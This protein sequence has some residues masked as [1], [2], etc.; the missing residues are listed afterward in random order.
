MDKKVIVIGV[1]Q[2]NFA[3]MNNNVNII[4]MVKESVFEE[5]VFVTNNMRES[6]AK[7]KVHANMTALK[8]A[9]VY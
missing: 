1:T 7:I 9:S 6:F 4:A 5:I 8:K 2:E 3:R